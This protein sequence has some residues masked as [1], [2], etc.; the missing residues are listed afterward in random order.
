[1][2]ALTENTG[3]GSIAVLRQFVRKPRLDSEEKCELC[4]KR[5]GDGHEHL[6]EL[7]NRRVLCACE[8]CAIL[9]S[10]HTAARYRRIPRQVRRLRDFALDD[11]EW[12]SLLIPINLAFFLYSSAEGRVVAQYPS[13]AGAMQSQL[14]LEYWAAIVE[15]CPTLK[16][17]ESDVEALLVNRVSQ[18]AQHYLAPIDHCYRLVGILRTH[19]RG[20]SGGQEVWKEV[21]RFFGE[22]RE[23]SF[24]VA[25]A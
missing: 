22:L 25:N 14:D 21:E 9:F 12:D 18:P 1:L 17:L 5:I 8:P 4:A 15:R 13:P 11:L 20:I 6:L 19:W 3:R 23:F 7:A 24:E 2:G 16:T 10:N